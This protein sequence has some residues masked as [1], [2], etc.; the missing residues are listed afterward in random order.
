MIVYSMD[1]LCSWIVGKIE[2]IVC[3]TIMMHG[4]KKEMKLDVME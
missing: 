2:S 4:M 1:F 3:L